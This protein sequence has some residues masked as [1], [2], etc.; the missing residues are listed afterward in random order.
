MN[1]SKKIVSPNKLLKSKWTAVSP[2]NKEKHFIVSK[3]VMP[4]SLDQPIA[5]I[6]LEAVY[7]RRIQL[8][9]WLQLNDADLWIQGWV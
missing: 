5:L 4:D 7:S 8:L 2:V 9:P 1:T 3:L 6:E